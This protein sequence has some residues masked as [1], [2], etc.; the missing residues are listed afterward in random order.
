MYYLPELENQSNLDIGFLLDRGR[1]D[2]LAQRAVSGIDLKDERMYYAISP[3]MKD[4]HERMMADPITLNM[5]L[6]KPQKIDLVVQGFKF[7]TAIATLEDHALEEVVIQQEDQNNDPDRLAW[8]TAWMSKSMSRISQLPDDVSCK[9]L[10]L[11]QI[12]K[13]R[14]AKLIDTDIGVL[15]QSLLISETGFL[16]QPNEDYLGKYARSQIQYF[17]MFMLSIPK[18]HPATIAHIARYCVSMV[19]VIGRGEVGFLPKYLKICLENSAPEKMPNI[20]PMMLE[21]IVEGI[22]ERIVY[23]GANPAS[24]AN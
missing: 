23:G 22:N 19:P 17:R 16:R 18:L 2:V 13:K 8:D 15:H 14:T 24:G 7:F 9:F 21:S 3:F 6:D 12:R 20:L 10:K 1:Y 5:T 11:D 4:L